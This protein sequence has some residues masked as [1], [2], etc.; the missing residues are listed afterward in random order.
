MA[1]IIAFA[2][3]YGASKLLFEKHEDAR[4]AAYIAEMEATGEKVPGIPNSEIKLQTNAIQGTLREDMGSFNGRTGIWSAA[5]KSF[6]NN[7][8]IQLRGT[9]D[10]V[11]AFMRE[12]CPFPAAHT[13]NSWLEMAVGFGIPGLLIALYFTIVA[14][15]D[16]AYLLCTPK[17]DL[18][19]KCI[20]MLVICLLGIGF[21]EPVLFVGYVDSQ[22]CNVVFFLC[23]GYMEQWRK[24][25]RLKST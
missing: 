17:C 10:V 12:G 7:P 24:D 1:A 6:L 19:K 8:R 2:A 14:I 22:Y 23:L 15:C 18:S 3:I 25:E 20:A 5:A 11:G 13:H 4:V 16:T 9:A 21:L